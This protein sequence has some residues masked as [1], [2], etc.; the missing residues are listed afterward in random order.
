MLFINKNKRGHRVNKMER[1][2]M[3]NMKSE[4]LL[5]WFEAYINYKD[6]EYMHEAYEEIKAEILRRM[7]EG[8]K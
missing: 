4:E 8:E 3:I 7:N 1:M 2:K 5:E 6:K